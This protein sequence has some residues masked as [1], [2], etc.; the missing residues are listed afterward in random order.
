MYVMFMQKIH[1][2]YVKHEWGM[3]RKITSITNNTKNMDFKISRGIWLKYDIR[4]L[5]NIESSL[6]T[7][8]WVKEKH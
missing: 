5:E 4:K 3:K 2:E 6:A 7:I 8:D 1:D